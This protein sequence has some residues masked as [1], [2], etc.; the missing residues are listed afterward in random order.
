MAAWFSKVFDKEEKKVPTDA[1]K[2]ANVEKTEEVMIPK[3]R[4]VVQAPVVVDE[5]AQSAY[6]DDVAIKAKVNDQGDL[7]VFMVDRPL[8]EGRSFWCPDAETAQE[9]S[10]MATAIFNVQGVKSV[11]IHGMNITVGRDQWT[12]STW[13][14]QCKEIGTEIRAQ[15]KSGM[16]VVA[17]ECIDSLPDTETIRAGLQKVIDE[18]LNPGIA[19]HGGIITLN[20]VE[21]NTAYITMGGG[22]QGCAASSITLR[23]G[24][25]TT[26]REAVPE[27]GAI[28]DETDHNAGSNPFFNELP[29]GM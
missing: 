6:S 12:T 8:L 29:A 20:R 19:S 17:P 15:I 10:P 27:V 22:C 23:Q 26:F 9:T 3:T 28:L 25:E 4:R 13:G 21:G 24:V 16:P 11:L 14:E 18:Q 7:I 5:S 2:T 1:G